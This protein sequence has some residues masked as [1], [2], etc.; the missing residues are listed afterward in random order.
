MLLDFL[1]YNVLVVHTKRGY[2]TIETQWTCFSHVRVYAFFPSVKMRNSAQCLLEY[3]ML[4]V[5]LCVRADNVV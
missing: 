2:I 5:F 4:L 1:S 3:T